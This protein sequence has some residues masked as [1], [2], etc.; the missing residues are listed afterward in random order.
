MD[1][2]EF[3]QEFNDSVRESAKLLESDFDSELASIIIEYIQDSG[4][5]GAPELCNF[6]K[7]NT[8]VTAC[9]YNIDGDSLDLFLLITTDV[10]LGKINN[11]LRARCGWRLPSGPSRTTISL[12]S[13]AR[14]HI[15]SAATA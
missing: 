6:S 3:A 11:E 9:D 7:R 5:V 2:K 4:E 1:L 15:V 8:A 12:R 13:T 14:W 10:T